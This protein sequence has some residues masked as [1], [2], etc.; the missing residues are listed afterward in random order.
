MV[1]MSFDFPVAPT[2]T[3]GD[4]DRCGVDGTFR[5]HV[6]AGPCGHRNAPNKTR[7]LGLPRSRRPPRTSK[8]QQV[9]HTTTIA[10]LITL[11]GQSA[12]SP[13]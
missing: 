1:T 9:S 11:T 8:A 13:Q 2:V 6:S 4:G 12:V 10:R 3:E 5:V 7:I